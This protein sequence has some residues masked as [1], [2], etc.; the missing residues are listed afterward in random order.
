MSKKCLGAALL[1]LCMGCGGGTNEEILTPPN[2]LVH[3]SDQTVAEGDAATFAVV[4]AGSDLLSY[5]WYRGTIA[6]FGATL[7]SYTV[8]TVALTDDGAQFSCYVTNASGSAISNVATLTV[9][10]PL[11]PI[12]TMH[13]SD[14]TVMEGQAATFT[15]TATGDPFPTYQWRKD[16]VNIDGA[17][18]LVYTISVTT[19]ADNGNQYD[20]IVTNIGGSIIS[21]SAILTVSAAP[22]SIV[23]NP[24]NQTVVEGQSATF[25]IVALGSGTLIYQWQRNGV[26]IP[27]ATEA[28]YTTPVMISTDDGTQFSC[29]VTNVGGSVTSDSATLIVN[30]ITFT[31][32]DANLMGVCDCALAWGDYDND[33]WPDLALAGYDGLNPITR[34]YRNDGGTFI[35]TRTLPG[36]RGGSLAWGDYDGDGWLDLAL[37]GLDSTSVISRVYHNAGGIFSNINA[38][39]VG[40]TACSLGWGDYDN[41][42][43][44]DLALAGASASEGYISRVYRNDG[45][46]FVAIGAGLT[47]VAICSIGWGDYDN[48]GWLDLALAGWVSGDTHIAKIYHNDGSDAFTDIGA[49]LVGVRRCSLSWGDYNNDG[50]I[51]LA[52][53]GATDSA[54]PY[55]PIAKIYRNDG[56]DVFTDINAGLVELVDCSLAWGDYDNDGD[57]DLALAGYDGVS[58]ISKIYRNDAGT[59]IDIGADLVNVSDCSLAW[60]DFDNDGDLDIALAGWD[61]SNYTSKIYRNDGGL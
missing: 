46:D 40:V 60:T 6:V 13:P 48:D 36:V 51:D 17:T 53:A 23:V 55:A 47:G 30:V 57:L 16:G 59:F 43:Y 2:I 29:V 12:I 27:G 49:G 26:N 8:T 39:L 19:F 32:I 42:G 37:A 9:I 45:G 28:D 18:D 20:C 11:P 58:P 1:V 52:S 31:D 7:P 44:L 61:G 14:Q 21:T 35:H 34:I 5:Q 41:D 3:P 25:S 15:I 56:I 10:T 54:P 50:R 24:M 33:G 22:P 38:G 4:A